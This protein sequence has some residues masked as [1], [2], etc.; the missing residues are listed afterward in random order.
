MRLRVFVAHSFRDEHHLTGLQEFRDAIKQCV[1]NIEVSHSHDGTQ[2]NLDLY[3]ED[4]RY[5]EPL[6]SA[7][8]EEIRYADLCIFDISGRVS[9]V[10]YELG[11][12]HGM[13]KPVITLEQGSSPPPSDLADV[14]IGHYA[15][16]A[17]LRSILGERLNAIIRETAL[18]QVRG[19]RR[20][21]HRCFWFEPTVRDIHIVCAG[22]TEL[23]RF[24]TPTATDYLNIDTFDD[25]DALFEVATFLARAYPDTKI[26]RHIAGQHSNDILDGNLVVLGGPRNNAVTNDLSSLVQCNYRY[27]EDKSALEIISGSSGIR[28]EPRIDDGLLVED[29]AYFGYFLNPFN[30]THRIVMSHGLHTFG[31]LGSALA[32]ADGHQAILNRSKLFGTNPE[33]DLTRFECG[34]RVPILRARRIAVPQLEDELTAIIC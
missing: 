28:L 15:S 14:L 23:T 21:S 19:T 29:V 18:K 24:A 8:R 33:L 3:F 5:G 4:A 10:F 12:A 31:T 32:F 20:P 2:L 34:L 25:R 11:F 9:N 30:Q 1:S 6:P 13:G 27:T 22:E 7:I 16:M 26:H 17:E